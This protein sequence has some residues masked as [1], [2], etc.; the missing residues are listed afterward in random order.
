MN[1][2]LKVLKNYAVFQGRA[3]RTEFWMFV[4]IN[5]VVAF[6]LT[7]VDM[8]LGTMTSSGYGMLGTLYG[9]A[10]LVPSIAVSVRRLHDTN[11]SG[12]WYLLIFVPL[13]GTIALLVFFVQDSQ[14]ENN[15][16]GPNPKSGG[17]S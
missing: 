3:R 14:P 13:I 9:L 10:V 1:W 2:Y 15:R 12:W 5:F 6:V 17:G 11:R 4:L 7:L 8:V 16:F